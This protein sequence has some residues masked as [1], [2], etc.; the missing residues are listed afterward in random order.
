[1]NSRKI[2]WNP[3]QFIASLSRGNFLHSQ[4]FIFVIGKIDFVEWGK[5]NKNPLL[6]S[7][8]GGFF[9][10][11][12]SS[13][14]VPKSARKILLTRKTSI[15]LWLFSSLK[16]A[17]Y[18]QE[19]SLWNIKHENAV[20]PA[21]LHPL[22]LHQHRTNKSSVIRSDANCWGEFFHF[23]FLLCL[24]QR[25]KSNHDVND[26]SEFLSSPWF[27]CSNG[28]WIEVKKTAA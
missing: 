25:T 2:F 21:S 17:P 19:L 3:T 10:R 16:R 9:L 1:M 15:V 26:T 5:V 27:C 4:C 8:W 12:Q 13:G 18:T 7:A 14:E 28:T 24:I 20:L 11:K 23:F 22:Y 6:T